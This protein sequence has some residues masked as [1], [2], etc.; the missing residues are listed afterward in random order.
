VRKRVVRRSAIGGKHVPIGIDT[1]CHQDHLRLCRL[2]TRTTSPG[3]RSHSTCTFVHLCA[4]VR[5]RTQEASC[6]AQCAARQ[7]DARLPGNSC[8]SPG[9]QTALLTRRWPRPARH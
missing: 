8:L 6:R 1:P 7:A 4:S 5:P 3:R 9:S 2:G